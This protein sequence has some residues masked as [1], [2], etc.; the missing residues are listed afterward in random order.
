MNPGIFA[1]SFA[2]LAAAAVIGGGLVTQG[3]VALA[4]SAP[5]TAPQSGATAPAAT[6]STAQHSPAAVEARIKQLH[7]QLKITPEQEA[8]WN[9]LAQIMRDNA[10]KLSDLIQQRAQNA[11]SMSAVDNLRSYEAITAAQEDGLKDL[12]PSF[13]KL[14]S[15]MSDAQKKTADAAFNQRIR[16]RVASQTKP[17]TPAKPSGG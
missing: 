10:S 8:Q 13:E 16:S 3:P 1:R 14:Y 4:Q 5:G 2:T 6:P 9:A 17:T 12:L 7:A 15:S 11:K